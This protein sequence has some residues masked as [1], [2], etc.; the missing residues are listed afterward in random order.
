[1]P[2]PR[3]ILCRTWSCDHF[4]PTDSSRTTTSDEAT[5]AAIE[6]EV[7]M[8]LSLE[9]FAFWRMNIDVVLSADIFSL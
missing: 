8:Q 5:V 6:Q 2:E 4:D 7:P 9:F 3:S 1:M